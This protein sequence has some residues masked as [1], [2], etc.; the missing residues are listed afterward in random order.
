VRVNKPFIALAST[1]AAVTLAGGIAFATWSVSG[2][3]QGAGAG[4]VVQ[5]L[6]VIPEVPT[7]SGASLYPG[8]PAGSVYFEVNNPNPFAVTI[9]SVAWGTPTSTITASCASSNIS[10]DGSAPTTVSIP[11]PAATTTGLLSIASVLDLA[12]S[13]PP[14]CQG[15]AFDVTMTITGA[16]Q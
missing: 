13:A 3:G 9:T 10:L 7:G 6:T 5:S 1:A 2:S 14:G 4:T 15:V 11:V 12:H 16:Q 8:G